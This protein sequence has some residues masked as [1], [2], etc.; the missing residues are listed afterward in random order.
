LTGAGAR[1]RNTT[2]RRFAP[3][4]FLALVA[5]FVAAPQARAI[6]AAG[7]CAGDATP[8]P[9]YTVFQVDGG[10]PPA[11]L[12]LGVA[13]GGG[14]VTLQ[15]FYTGGG[16]PTLDLSGLLSGADT[17]HVVMDFGSY[18]PHFFDTTGMAVNYSVDT[19][20][21]SHTIVTLDA[22]PRPSAWANSCTVNSCPTTAT[23]DFGEMLLA[24]FTDLAGA[25][26]PSLVSEIDGSWVSTNAQAIA[27]PPTFDA[28]TSAF[29]FHLAAPHYKTDGSTL[30][31]GFFRA[32]L[33]DSV[34]ESMGIADPSS[35]TDSSF[36][37]ANSNGGTVSVTVCHTTDSSC[38][39]D[40]G[41]SGVVIDAPLGSF[42]YSS[43]TFTIT[44]ASP[45]PALDHFTVMAAGGGDV[46]T[47]TAGHA[48]SV[49]VTAKTAAGAT[50][51]GFSG[52]VDIGS[53]RTCTAGCS[54]PVSGFSNG[55]VTK[56]IT[57]TKSGSG[58]T[59]SATDHGGS[60]TGTS[61][62]FLINPAAA[63]RLAFVSTSSGDL[64]SGTSRVLKAEIRDA[65]GNKVTAGV[66]T[67]TFSKVSG[68]G[69]V[70]GLPASVSSS[71]GVASKSVSGLKAGSLTLHAGVAG[72][73]AASLTFAVVHGPAYKLVFTSGTAN[74][75]V[76]QSRML[77]V[78]VRDHA[79][80]LV[81]SPNVSVTFAKTA[82]TGAVSGLG[83]ATS[84]SGI[85]SKTV[86]AT[87]VGTIGIAATSGGLVSA[88][89]SFSITS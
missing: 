40:S 69:T 36:D 30:N 70:N 63:A 48:F 43:P 39:I 59:V 76:G 82:G 17:V 11:G 68:A 81:P 52:S 5:L 31:T 62:A 10:S 16:V 6:R 24:A 2:A 20:D 66:S 64:A 88:A 29:S 15:V 73:T 84:S 18:V 53:N 72:L 14:N 7:V 89:T 79:G 47:Q 71:Q 83:G 37:V 35:V 46:A 56:S 75:L 22:D 1:G 60:K 26:D 3:L 23:F 41:P 45:T 34:V 54:S 87:K 77:K 85:A 80:N 12:S 25:P 19:T 33:P 86:T 49:K 61:N 50:L 21:A 74:L 4:L 13:S 8:R 67:V 32:F 65:Y 57:L 58:A 9:C 44:S 78:E 38:V 28:A 27:L 55:S 42:S 51:T